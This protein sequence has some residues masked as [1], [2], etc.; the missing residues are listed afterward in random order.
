M[1]VPAMVLGAD[2]NSR[3]ESVT[4]GA[5]PPY[6]LEHVSGLGAAPCDL[7]RTSGVYQH[8]ASVQRLRHN[9]RNIDIRFHVD[10]RP[11]RTRMY[12]Y[13]E[14]L[15]RV[16]SPQ[17][18][19]NEETGGAATLRYENDHGK[20]WLRAIPDGPDFDKRL[21]DFMVSCP[22]TFICPSPFFQTLGFSTLA[23]EM[24][25]SAFRLP[26]E[27]PIC[28][29]SLQYRGSAVN[30]GHVDAPVVIE[31]NG[32][33]EKPRLINHTTGAEIE[34]SRNLAFGEK[35]RVDTDPDRPSVT[36]VDPSGAETSAYGY[37]GVRS[38][39]SEF[40]LRPGTNDLEYRPSEASAASRVTIAWRGL[41]EGV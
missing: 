2:Q 25:D 30:I 35:L 20:W 4:F 12:A 36:L 22:L 3:S 26:F 34:V 32:S 28:L 18:A 19:L 10:G 27:F 21:Q 13:R 40:F 24:T 1:A 6:V 39:V 5:G 8:G 17:H 38:A 41:L 31:I 14:R 16:L 15:M 11:S 37:L 23:L 33:G 7:T 29:G 9:A